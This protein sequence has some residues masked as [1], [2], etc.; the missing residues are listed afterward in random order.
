[1]KTYP[2]KSD[3]RYSIAL[4]FCGH[5][6]KRYVLRFC[7]EFIASSISRSAMAVRAVGHNAVRNGALVIEEVKA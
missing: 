4:E 6:E 5:P 7:D 2:I 1:M 3:S